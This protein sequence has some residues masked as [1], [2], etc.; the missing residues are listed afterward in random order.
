MIKIKGRYTVGKQL[1]SWK[2][3]LAQ[4]ITFVVT[5][6]CNLRCKY[7]Y[8]TGKASNK[9]LNYETATKFIDYIFT[10]NFV[11][12]EAVIVEFIGG[13]PFMEVELIDKVMDYFKTVAFE[14]GSDWAWNYR[15]SICTNGVNYDSQQV[16]DFIKK[17]YGK[18]S[19]TITLDGTKA[20]HDLNR[21]FPDGSGSYD[22]IMKNIPTW[23]KQFGGS[24]K[25]T[26]ASADLGYLKDSIIE[27]WNMGIKEIA[28]NV[29]FED[30]W[31]D[32]DDEILEA[33]LKDLA[34]Y[35]LDNEIYN[36]G[37]YC[38][39]FDEN[40]GGYY[41]EEDLG[42]TSCGAG[43][44]IA[45]GPNG[46][47]YPCIRYKDYSLNRH[48]EWTIGTVDTGIDMEKVRP[49]MTA[50]TR[51]QSDEECINCE[52]GNGCGFCQ[53]FNY[54]DADMPTNFA[55]AKYICKMH[56]ARV[57]ANEYYFN[58]LYNRFGIEK[59]SPRRETKK[60]YFLLADDYVT[61]C[62]H[63]NTM[64][65][66]N[67][68]SEDAILKGLEY[69]HKNFFEPVMVHSKS[70]FEFTNKKEYENYRIRHI[71]PAKF[72]A[73]SQE[74]KDV[75]YVFEKED[76]D[77]NISGLENCIFVIDA[78]GIG[79]L[80]KDVLK[81]LEKAADVDLYITNLNREF[82]E[83]LYEEQLLN[84]EQYLVKTCQKTKVLH[85]VNVITDVLDKEGHKG[86]MAGYR[87][88][89]YAPDEN[90]YV[91]SAYYKA[92]DF[93]AVGNV[94]DGLVNHKSK[95]LYTQKYNPLCNTCDAYQCNNCTYMNQT[96]TNEV[97][98]A[99]SY[100]CRKG[101]IERRV[102]LKFHKDTNYGRDIEPKAS[103]DQ[104]GNVI[105]KA[106]SFKGYYKYSE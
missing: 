10:D 65:S 83:G 11:R 1:E 96:V 3:G 28:S 34:D 53:G 18:L 54:D 86:C 29:V 36:D 101:H 73:K 72:Y 2:D 44:M 49:F 89:A 62:E 87:S 7:C 61:Y 77:A 98:V 99:P 16:Q 46:N 84:I 60:M 26:F 30:A 80:A 88:F 104:I 22:T 71:V 100:K 91:C 95:H 45:V 47:L 51:L 75:T 93:A 41:N 39:F 92:D 69:A 14:K 42:R 105:D 23:I 97:N 78:N 15:I 55:R 76:L 27:L 25:V 13:E 21:V 24:T 66:Q 58:K 64:T 12:S 85:T 102:A 35:V 68:M 19:L 63:E 31:N 48:K 81:L 52:I 57:R 17:N 43:K 33:Q 82:D 4:T 106:D 103:M 38:T 50:S 5:E 6:D 20:K 90:I 8:I 9:R 94:N 56:K 40:L 79:D 59:E 67:R 74:L 70:S 37:Y 32:G